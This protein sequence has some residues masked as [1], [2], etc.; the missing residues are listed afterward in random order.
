M[1]EF[2]RCHGDLRFV[3]LETHVRDLDFVVSGCEI[4]EGE[5]PTLVGRY[6]QA[7]GLQLHLSALEN[8]AG[9]VDDSSGDH[10]FGID[11]GGG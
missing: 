7:L 11:S 10:A 8:C 2:A 4:G 6:R 1:L 3:G 9:T 5:F